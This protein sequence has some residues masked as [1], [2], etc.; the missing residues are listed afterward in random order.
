MH[1][2]RILLLAYWQKDSTQ[3]QT[4]ACK[5]DMLAQA[6]RQDTDMCYCQYP[7]Y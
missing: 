6:V 4:V 2:E 5:R 1:I 7:S 3:K